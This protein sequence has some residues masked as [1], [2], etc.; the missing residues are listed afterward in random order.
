MRFSALLLI[1]T[2]AAS[3]AEYIVYLGTY[4]NAGKSQ[5][6]YAYRFDSDSGKLSEIGLAA[7]ATNPSFLAIHPN[8]KYLIPRPPS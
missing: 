3:A 8:R 4:T 5:G 6:I 1:L 7:Q 2:W